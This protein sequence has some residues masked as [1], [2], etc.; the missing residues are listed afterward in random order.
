M[1]F[2]CVHSQA[3]VP[4]LNPDPSDAFTSPT[5][6]QPAATVDQRS[7]DPSLLVPSA[8]TAFGPLE[9]QAYY[10]IEHL[11]RAGQR[12]RNRCVAGLSV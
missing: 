12:K 5:A 3:N 9:R 10:L 6:E 4:D 11:A 1:I 7:S 8:P 2:L